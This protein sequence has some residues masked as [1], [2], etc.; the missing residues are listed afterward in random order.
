MTGVVKHDVEGTT[1][2]SQIF[3][4]YPVALIPDEDFNASEAVI[5]FACIIVDTKD[6][7]LGKVVAPDTQRRNLFASE[8]NLQKLDRL[9]PERREQPLIEVQ[10]VVARRGFVGA[11]FEAEL[12]E[13]H[14]AATIWCATAAFLDRAISARS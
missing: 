4:K 10:I 6:G 13:D 3:E 11:V 7:G 1:F 8:S 14:R 12:V 9:I 5:L 2:A